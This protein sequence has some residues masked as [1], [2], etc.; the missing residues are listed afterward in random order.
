[1][2]GCEDCG[3]C[4]SLCERH[5]LAQHYLS[6]ESLFG[7]LDTKELIDNKNYCPLWPSLRTAL[8]EGKT[9]RVRCTTVIGV[10]SQLLELSTGIPFASEIS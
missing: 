4:L 6:A 3:H 9:L 8:P 1:M 2:G 7:E 5:R 10:P